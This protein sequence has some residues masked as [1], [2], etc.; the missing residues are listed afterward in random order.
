MGSKIVQGKTAEVSSFCRQ[1][2]RPLGSHWPGHHKEA[3]ENSGSQQS[4]SAHAPKLAGVPGERVERL[5]VHGNPT[6]QPSGSLQS[7]ACEIPVLVGGTWAG[8]LMGEQRG[9]VGG[10]GSFWGTFALM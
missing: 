10:Q 6:L 1:V 9:G 4:I 2:P 8:G 7:I 3:E 5:S